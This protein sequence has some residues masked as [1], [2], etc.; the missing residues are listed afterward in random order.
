MS[1]FTERFTLAVASRT[2]NNCTCLFLATVSCPWKDAFALKFLFIFM[3]ITVALV[4]TSY[5]F[6]SILEA[7]KKSDKVNLE[8]RP[9]GT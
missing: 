2:Y 7:K 8:N 5:P 3:K 6:T 9:I 1:Y 4:E